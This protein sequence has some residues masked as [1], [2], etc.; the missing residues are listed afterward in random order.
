MIASQEVVAALTASGRGV[1]RPGESRGQDPLVVHGSFPWPQRENKT[2]GWDNDLNASEEQMGTLLK[3]GMGGR[4]EGVLTIAPHVVSESA[5]IGFSVKDYGA[6]A[7]ENIAPTLRAMNHTDSH[8]NGGGQLG[9]VSFPWPQE[10]ADPLTS[11]EAK[12]YT[13]AYAVALRGRE[14]GNTAELGGEI[15]PALRTGGGGSDKPHVL[16]AASQDPFVF[17]TT[18][19][20]HPA[21]FSPPKP[22]DPSHPLAAAG[23]A[24]TLVFESR[25]YTREN[26]T[27]GAPD[28]HVTA[29]LRADL[30]KVGDGFP[31]IATSMV[32]RRL[33]PRE[34]ER[35][36]GFPDSWTLIPWRG[37]PADQC[38][39][40]PRYKALGN[41]MA[42][43]VM[44]WIGRRIDA[45][46]SPG[47][48]HD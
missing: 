21:N 11:N 16:V 42:V 23:H 30:S 31:T 24:P 37:K 36:Q 47:K 22:G 40:G 41:S 17:D 45:H 7:Q 9:V 32:V 19:A 27:A 13:H 33:T 12:T 3:G 29:P 4:H 25:Y 35:L 38:P 1:E 39:D 18:Q 26:K 20:T 44:R 46:T 48:T 28:E 2:I 14:G 10:V 43:P 34:C 15:Q 6:D 8:A 5:P